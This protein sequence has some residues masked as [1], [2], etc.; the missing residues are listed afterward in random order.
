MLD[1]GMN[2]PV[3][4]LL[5]LWVNHSHGMWK[6]QSVDEERIAN[7]R[8]INEVLDKHGIPYIQIT[9]IDETN[10][11]LEYYYRGNKVEKKISYDQA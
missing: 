5:K 7:L 1:I 4:E 3:E 10:Y 2:T 6:T 8:Y 9:S 11:T